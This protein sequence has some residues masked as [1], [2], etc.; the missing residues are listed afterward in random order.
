MLAR[1]PGSGSG[2]TASALRSGVPNLVIPF[3]ADQLFWGNKVF[4]IGAG[5]APIPENKVTM[6]KILEAIDFVQT[7]HCKSKASEISSHILTEHGLENVIKVIE[8]QKR[9]I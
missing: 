7:N 3:G 8:S 5:P 6:Q 2:T 1:N 4:E 9:A